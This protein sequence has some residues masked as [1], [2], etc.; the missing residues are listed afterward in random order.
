MCLVC[1]TALKCPVLNITIKVSHRSWKEFML[2][3]QRLGR[4]KR[5]YVATVLDI[6]WHLV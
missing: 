6:P 3:I 5:I 1:W 4:I 2:M